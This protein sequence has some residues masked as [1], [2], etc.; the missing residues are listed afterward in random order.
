MGGDALFSMKA[1]KGS[2]PLI[3]NFVKTMFKFSIEAFSNCELNILQA[4]QDGVEK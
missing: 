2:S 4:M 3:F 1:A